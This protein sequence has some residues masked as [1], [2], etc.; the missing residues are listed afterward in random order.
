MESKIATMIKEEQETWKICELRLI[1]SI[2]EKSEIIRDEILKESENREINLKKLVEIQ[3]QDIP[4][5]EWGVKSLVLER[6]EM[7]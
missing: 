4:W 6:E 1:E 2:E 5:I 3:E 7:E